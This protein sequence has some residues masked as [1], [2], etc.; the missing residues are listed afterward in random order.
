[1]HLL[2]IAA[3][4]A[5]LLNLALAIFVLRQDT[6]S[7]LHGAYFVWGLGV[8]LWNLACV[9]LY[10]EV[11]HG[12]AVF[13]AKMVQLGI[14]LAPLGFY[15]TA[16]L[17][18]GRSEN[19]K[20]TIAFLTLHGF[21]ALSLFGHWFVKDVR[22]IGTLGY[23]SV[24]GWLFWAYPVSYTILIYS[25]LIFLY[26]ASQQAT[27]LQRTRLR[28]MLL[29][30]LLMSVAGTNDFLPILGID[31]YP[32]INKPFYPFGNITACLYMTI[33]AYSVLQHTLLDVHVALGRFTAHAV[34]FGFLALCSL[35]MLM[36]LAL[37]FPQHFNGV[38]FGGALLVQILSAITASTLFPRLFGAGAET[39]ERKIL[40]DRL[41]YRD[42]VR[43]F[44][45]SMTWFTDFPSLF[46]EL[47]LL[48]VK[49]FRLESYTILLR[50]VTG[51]FQLYR[52]HPAE[53][54]N[55]VP[56]M[57][58]D[59]P[60]AR[61]FEE[62]DVTC[63]TLAG[64]RVGPAATEEEA[65]LQLAEFGAALCFA[66]RS[67][68]EAMGFLMIGRKIGGDPFTVTDIN[69]FT[70]LVKAMGVV[71][72]Q[73]RMK[74]Q[75]SQAQEFELLGRMS[76][77]MAHDLNNLLTPV[78]TLL[79]LGDET[80]VLDDEL[81]PV[82]ARNV[83]AIRAYI[84]EGLFFSEHHR[85]DFQGGRLDMVIARAIEV[86]RGS[87]SAGVSI[88]NE[89]AGEV[90]AEMDAVMVQRLLANLITNA[91]DASPAGSKVTVAVDHRS[92]SDEER[93]WL[94]IRVIDE[95]QGIAAADIDRVFTPYFTT[96]NTGDSH[97]GF[98]LGLAICRKI[99][100]LHGGELSIDSELHRGTTVIFDL[101]SKQIFPATAQT[102][103]NFRAA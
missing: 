36:L 63:L 28:A 17:I 70:S 16:R 74:M 59:S 66:I 96:K 92:P 72:N 95:G 71:V 22:Y 35:C 1:M 64:L 49:S 57:T 39:F 42:Q 50:D 37:A 85:L 24:P 75:I 18:S 8:S 81:L 77:G 4:C 79:Q 14:I 7:R 52:T 45:Q 89:V 86:A 9:F 83:M 80:G 69:L 20:A 43:A 23:W 15:E 19:R 76:S 100:V 10:G 87:R 54:A 33:V 60:V 32:I 91:I 11:S 82:A 61:Y 93:D 48:L 94:R 13:W 53:L 58:R 41:E 47:H 25:P 12:A 68:E 62:E 103:V 88:V 38:A 55:G 5:C 21:F 73:I 2:E 40:G 27:S 98:G 44:V 34:R 29:A 56:E 3:L 97:R 99:A 102:P 31:Q 51:H 78:S 84:R 30:L 46:S 65:R 26:Q 101:P 90:W 67:H 6:R